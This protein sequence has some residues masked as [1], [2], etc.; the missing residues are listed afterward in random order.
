MMETQM[1][2][3]VTENLTPGLEKDAGFKI[4]IPGP[5]SSSYLPVVIH[6]ARKS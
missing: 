5:A 6:P 4:A 3:K 1:S 2:D